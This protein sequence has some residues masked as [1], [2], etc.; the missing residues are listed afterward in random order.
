[1]WY[2]GD[3]L[4]TCNMHHVCWPVSQQRTGMMQSRGGRVKLRHLQRWA[5][6]EKMKHELRCSGK[7]SETLL[8]M[9]LTFIKKN[10]FTLFLNDQSHIINKYSQRCKKKKKHGRTRFLTVSSS[11]DVCVLVSP[12]RRLHINKLTVMNDSNHVYWLARAP[13]A[14][15]SVSTGHCV[16]DS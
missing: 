6:T 15:K 3:L 9:M 2:F 13:S 1:M 11:W 7:K 8:F 16:E 10:N 14:L 5:K 12:C 4:P